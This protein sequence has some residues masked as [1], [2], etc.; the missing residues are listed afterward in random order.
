MEKAKLMQEEIENR[1]KLPKEVKEKIKQ[2]TRRYAKRQ[3]TFFK[4]MPE[5]QFVSVDENLYKEIDNW[6]KNK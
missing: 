5:V 6:L 2:A 1:R 4:K 3:I